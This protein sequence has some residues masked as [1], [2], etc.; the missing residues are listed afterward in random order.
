VGAAILLILIALAALAPPPFAGPAD[1]VDAFYVPKPEWNFLFLYQALKFFPG[2]WEPL[3]TVG[4]PLLIVV[5]LILVP[6]IDRREQRD[7]RRRPWAMTAGVLWLVAL[8]TLTFAG[9][10]S[11]PGGTAQEPAVL[12]ASTTAPESAAVRSGAALFRSLG[13]EA[14]HRVNGT[15][16]T[17]GPDLSNEALKG[18]SRA[19]L[20]TQVSDPRKHDA[21]TPMPAFSTLTAGQLGDLADYLASLGVERG[22]GKGSRSVSPAAAETAPPAAAAPTPTPAASTALEATGA[23]GPAARVIGSAD[24]GAKLFARY[25][26]PCHGA[27]GRG[28]VSNI[29]RL[30]PIAPALF[31]TDAQTFADTVDRIVQHGLKPGG[32]GRKP[33]MPAFGDTHSLTQQEIADIEAYVLKLNGVARGP[34]VAPGLDPERFFVLSLALFGLAGIVLGAVWLRLTSGRSK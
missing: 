33:A 8:F 16:G 6:F 25:C 4:I 22:G 34:L 29:P 19:W 30:N 1:P 32:G 11:K 31:D 13:C 17:V 28:G 7:P 18:H 5:A 9:Y 20:M 2:R 14:C 24:H 26:Q 21:A 3:G 10:Y 15:G 23:P 12:S 27:W